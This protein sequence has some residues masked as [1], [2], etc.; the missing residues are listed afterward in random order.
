MAGVDA[1]CHQGMVC[2]AVVV[3]DFPR[4]KPNEQAVVEIPPFVS[5]YIVSL[6]PGILAALKQLFQCRSLAD[7]ARSTRV[8]WPSLPPK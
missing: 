7:M 4:L 2:A 5:L 3:L 6:S 8:V 1:S